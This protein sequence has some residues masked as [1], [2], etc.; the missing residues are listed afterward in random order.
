MYDPQSDGKDRISRKIIA[1]TPG[2]VVPGVFLY[3]YIEKGNQSLKNSTDA[4]FSVPR[5][6]NN[7]SSRMAFHNIY[8]HGFKK[9]TSVKNNYKLE[10]IIFL[11]TFYSADTSIMVKEVIHGYRKLL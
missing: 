7:R 9:V 1:K 3:E 5:I 4:S 2:L 6:A 8:V 10:N 11:R